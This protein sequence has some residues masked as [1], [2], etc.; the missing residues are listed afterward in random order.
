[1]Q[2][3]VDANTQKTYE[4]KQ[5]T[6]ENVIGAFYLLSIGLLIAVFILFIE[7]F[8]HKQINK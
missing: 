5:I 2:A 1:M 7:I 4:P 8:M 3:L 6:L